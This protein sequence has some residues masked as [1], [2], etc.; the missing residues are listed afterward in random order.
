VLPKGARLPV[1]FQCAVKFGSPLYYR[2]Q[3]GR[4]AFLDRAQLALE[5]I[6]RQA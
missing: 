5:V 2:P 3:E 4:E 6:G 1:P